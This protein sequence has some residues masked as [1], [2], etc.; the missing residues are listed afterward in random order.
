[1]TMELDAEQLSVAVAAQLT[2]WS[3]VS[4]PGPVLVEMLA[5]QVTTGGVVSTT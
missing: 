1:M 3:Q 2:T 4:L 5:G